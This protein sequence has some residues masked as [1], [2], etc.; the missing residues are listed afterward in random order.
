[1]QPTR[2]KLIA[3]ST[4]S[5][6][7]RKAV[8]DGQIRRSTGSAAAKARQGPTMDKRWEAQ[9]AFLWAVQVARMSGADMDGCRVYLGRAWEIAEFHMRN[10]AKT[11]AKMKVVSLREATAEQLRTRLAELSSDEETES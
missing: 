1:M 9:E 10:Y 4:S 2:R 8:V 5:T 3:T 6:I 11:Q 7:R